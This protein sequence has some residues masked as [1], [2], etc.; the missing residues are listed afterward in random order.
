M[1][2]SET[3]EAGL[4]IR[5]IPKT[6]ERI[7][8]I[9]LGTWQTFDIGSGADERAGRRAVLERLFA[10]GGSVIDSSPMY[11]RAETVV[12]DLLAEMQARDRAFIA[13]KVWT[14]GRG[15]GIE[16]M[17]ASLRKFR[18]ERIDLMQVHNLV[19]WRTHLGTLEGWKKEGWVRYVGLTHY[20][21]SALSDLAEIVERTPVDFLQFIYSLDAPAAERRLLP[22]CAD[23]GIATLINRPFGGGSMLS[24]T[25]GR[26]LP[27]LA[28]E[29]GC[30]TWAQFALKYVL[31]HPAVTCVI[32]GTGNSNHMADNL[33]AGTGRLPTDGERTRMRAVWREA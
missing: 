16:Q 22:L 26:K 8:A 1:S 7:P 14:S 10:A 11:G 19:D 32:P 31:G 24:R 12:G 28:A 3:P 9:G 13:T 30:T 23:R 25:R 27:P 33:A 4:A 21:E 20:T 17:T 5:A 6:G 29:L 18:V 15:A 2:S